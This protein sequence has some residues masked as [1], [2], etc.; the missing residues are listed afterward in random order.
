MRIS[1]W[2]SDVGSS[3]LPGCLPAGGQAVSAALIFAAERLGR[4][5]PALGVVLLVFVWWLATVMELA[6]PVLLPPPQEALKALVDGLVSGPLL[7][8]FWQTIYRTVLSFAIASAIAIPLGVILRS[9]E[10]T[11]ELQSLMRISY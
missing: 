8:D 6:D 1:D 9:E 11:S 10:H 7:F 4:L 5:R 2:S 3:D